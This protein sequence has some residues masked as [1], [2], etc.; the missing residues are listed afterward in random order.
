MQAGRL[1]LLE[2]AERPLHDRRR[3]D[4]DVIQTASSTERFERSEVR[5]IDVRASDHNRTRGGRSATG[6]RIGGLIPAGL[7][8]STL[9]DAEA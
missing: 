2:R 6:E 9:H 4:P 7:K 8:K 5:T 1:A 3:S